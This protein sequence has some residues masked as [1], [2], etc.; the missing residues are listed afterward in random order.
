VWLVTVAPSVYFIACRFYGKYI[1][2]T[3]L[4]ITPAI[5]CSRAADFLRSIGRKYGKSGPR[6]G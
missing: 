2:R 1:S 4:R 5:P 3:W 6:C